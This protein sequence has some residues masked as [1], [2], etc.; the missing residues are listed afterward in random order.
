MELNDN[1]VVAIKQDDY[2]LLRAYVDGTATLAD[3]LNRFGVNEDGHICI[4]VHI[5][6]GSLGD[7]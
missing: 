7:G 5:V 6:G 3:L 4:P 2:D 1:D